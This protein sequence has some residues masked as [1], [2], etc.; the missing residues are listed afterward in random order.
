MQYVWTVDDGNIFWSKGREILV[1]TL[2]NMIVHMY[3]GSNNNEI[4]KIEYATKLSRFCC[5]ME[6]NF[7]DF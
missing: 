6:L 7:S 1:F 5:Y 3:K 4:I 2:E